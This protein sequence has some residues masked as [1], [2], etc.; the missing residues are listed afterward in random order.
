MHHA[1]LLFALLLPPGPLLA[2]DVD[3]ELVLLTDAS[4][5]ID[6]VELDLQ[7]QGYAAAITS[8]E[9]IDAIGDTGYGRIAVTYVEFAATT[10]VVVPWTM[11]SSAEEARAF[12]DAIL[13]APR[14]AI[15]GNGIGAALLYG[16]D[17]I[18]E[19]EIDGWRK[20]IDFSSDSLWNSSG[21]AI[22]PSRQSVLD[23]G[24][25]INGLPVLC[26]DCS[27]RPA[28][29]NLEQDY[30]DRLIGGRGA[31][32]VTADSNQSF[33]D[34][35][36]RK[37]VIEISGMHGAPANDIAVSNAVEQARDGAGQPR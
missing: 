20:V 7:R 9:V 35:V 36:R 33:Q 30:L 17:L 2:Q 21:P 37:L 10:E 18:E 25:T 8:P 15:G 24:I 11:I 22:A 6:Q 34:A 26:D 3:L 4:R 27:G 5:S 23:A 16:R 19:N 31:F 32:M 13:P 28:S 29:Q 14:E 1:H 12:A